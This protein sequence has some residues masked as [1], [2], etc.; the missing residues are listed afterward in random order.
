MVSSRPGCLAKHAVVMDG[1][2]SNMHQLKA[3]CTLTIVVAWE[4]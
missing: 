2:P 3:L 1:L 4:Q